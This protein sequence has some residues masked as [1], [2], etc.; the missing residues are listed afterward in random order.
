[1]DL[2]GLEVLTPREGSEGEARAALSREPK[3]LQARVAALLGPS[4]AG[5]VLRLGLG[6][7]SADFPSLKVVLIVCFSG[8]GDDRLALSLLAGSSG[9]TGVAVGAELEMKSPFG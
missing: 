9:E 6:G 5:R 8:L 1:M 2:L 4:P 3:A 7:L